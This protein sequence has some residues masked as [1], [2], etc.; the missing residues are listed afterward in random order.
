LEKLLQTKEEEGRDKEEEE[1]AEKEEG[2]KLIEVK[3]IHEI[4]FT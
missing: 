2:K 3:I 4:G 1:E